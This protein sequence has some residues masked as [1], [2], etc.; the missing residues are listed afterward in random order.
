MKDQRD[1]EIVVGNPYRYVFA[2]PGPDCTLLVCT[3]FSKDKVKCRDLYFNCDIEVDPK[4]LLQRYKFEW[5]ADEI[6]RVR[7]FGGN[8]KMMEE[9]NRS[10]KNG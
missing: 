6:Q 4:Q 5:D 10:I 8:F 1:N 3:G 7:K 2:M 9:H